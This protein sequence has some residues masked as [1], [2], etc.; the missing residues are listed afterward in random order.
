ME[1]IECPYSP[2][3]DWGNIDRCGTKLV[4]VTIAT[5]NTGGLRDAVLQHIK[6]LNEAELYQ[7]PYFSSVLISVYL[8][9]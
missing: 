7:L 1:C 3:F 9:S 4:P 5:Y 2:I 6:F 8:D